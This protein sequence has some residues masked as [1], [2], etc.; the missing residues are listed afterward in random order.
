MLKRSGTKRQRHAIKGNR[1]GK[2]GHSKS[3][4][5]CIII[6]YQTSSSLYHADTMIV[7]INCRATNADLF[8]Q[9]N[10][11]APSTV[12]LSVEGE[13]MKTPGEVNTKGCQAKC[14]C[15]L[16]AMASQVQLKIIAPRG[17]WM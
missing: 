3:Y 17:I 16:P 11:D 2:S 13:F 10:K 8:W 4:N 15:V 1:D 5:A 7:R 6:S 12:T 14:F 9:N